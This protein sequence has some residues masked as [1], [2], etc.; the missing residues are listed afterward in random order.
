MAGSGAGGQRGWGGRRVVARGCSWLGMG[1]TGVLAPRRTVQ[2][3]GASPHSTGPSWHCGTM[4]FS[5]LP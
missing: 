1:H 3:W 5:R 2:E 4:Q